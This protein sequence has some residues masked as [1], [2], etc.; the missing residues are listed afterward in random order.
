MQTASAQ[1]EGAAICQTLSGKF[2][3]GNWRTPSAKLVAS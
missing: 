2:E 1:F 3:K